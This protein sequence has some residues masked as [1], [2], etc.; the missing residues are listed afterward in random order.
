MVSQARNAAMMQTLLMTNSAGTMTLRRIAESRIT[1]PS[2]AHGKIPYMKRTNKIQTKARNVLESESDVM[3][4]LSL[5]RS[6]TSRRIRALSRGDR[7][8]HEKLLRKLPEIER[9][10]WAGFR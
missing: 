2:L 5:L 3:R 4:R 9:R 6:R 10:V 8:M 7:Q 1:H